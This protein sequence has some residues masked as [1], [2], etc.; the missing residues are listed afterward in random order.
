MDMLLNVNGKPITA[1]VLNPE[2]VA[3]RFRKRE[4]R[5]FEEASKRCFRMA[6]FGQQCNWPK[7]ITDDLINFAILLG[8]VCVAKR[9]GMIRDV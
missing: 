9:E 7:N 3:K 5:E 6:Q 2:E 8:E 1:Q 4:A